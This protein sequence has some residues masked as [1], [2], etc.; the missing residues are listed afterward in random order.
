MYRSFLLTWIQC[1]IL[2]IIIIILIKCQSSAKTTQPDGFTTPIQPVARFSSL[3]HYPFL[4]FPQ[5]LPALLCLS[6][7]SALPRRLTLKI[8]TH[9]RDVVRTDEDALAAADWNGQQQVVHLINLIQQNRTIQQW[10]ALDTLRSM[11]I[12]RPIEKQ[13]AKLSLG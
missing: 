8:A 1:Q 12:Q 13:E 10:P 9:T 5:F 4:S 6:H 3:L 2:H 7:F 11:N